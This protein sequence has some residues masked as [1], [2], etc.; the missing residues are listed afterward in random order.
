MKPVGREQV[1]ENLR[2]HFAQLERAA[3]RSQADRAVLAFGLAPLDRRLPGGGLPLGCLHE[4]ELGGCASQ[5]E[6][7]T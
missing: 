3:S 5:T 1:L 4:V 2:E 7:S 6:I